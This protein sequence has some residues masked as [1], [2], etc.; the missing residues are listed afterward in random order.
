MNSQR[1]MQH[2]KGLKESKPDGVQKLKET[3]E[4]MPSPLTKKLSLNDNPLQTEI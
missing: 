4:F 2:P 1:L 3:H